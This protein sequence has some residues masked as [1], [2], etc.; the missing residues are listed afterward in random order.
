MATASASTIQYAG[1]GVYNSTN[2][3][4]QLVQQAYAGGMRNFTAG[5]QWGGDPAPGERKYLYILWNQ[6]GGEVSGVTGEG[7]QRGVQVP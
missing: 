1:Y 3:A 6:N 4:T 2:D 5:N 7:D